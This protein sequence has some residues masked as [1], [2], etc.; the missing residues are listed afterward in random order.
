M[1]I[2]LAILQGGVGGTKMGM[3]NYR[4]R[5]VQCTCSP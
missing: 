3:E 5:P 1:N 4:A 2:P